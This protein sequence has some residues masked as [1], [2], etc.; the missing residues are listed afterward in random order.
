MMRQ[1]ISIQFHI[2]DLFRLVTNHKAVPEK[3]VVSPED[4]IRHSQKNQW[5]KVQCWNQLSIM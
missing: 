5:A 2:S 3:R 4:I 1:M